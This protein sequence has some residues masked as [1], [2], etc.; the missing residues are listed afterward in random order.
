MLKKHFNV[1]KK[2]HTNAFSGQV[3]S[4]T[5]FLVLR[6]HNYVW[7]DLKRPVFSYVFKEVNTHGKI[8]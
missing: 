4:L 2:V 7:T 3:K 8:S 1:S 5:L 6:Y